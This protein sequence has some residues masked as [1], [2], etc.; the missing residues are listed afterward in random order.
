MAKIVSNN[1]CFSGVPVKMFYG[2]K[3]N[4]SNKDRLRKIVIIVQDFLY[5]K[6]AT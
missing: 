5:F 4:M 2:N 6:V 1:H 3:Y